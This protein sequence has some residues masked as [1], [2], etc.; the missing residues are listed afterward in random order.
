M[1]SGFGGRLH[2]IRSDFILV[3]FTEQTTSTNKYWNGVIFLKYIFP[4]I[5]L[6]R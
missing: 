4:L 5:F 6:I 1:D 2:D 3:I